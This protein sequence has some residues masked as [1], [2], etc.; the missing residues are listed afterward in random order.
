MGACQGALAVYTVGQ[1]RIAKEHCN[2]FL[3]RPKGF[4]KPRPRDA[5]LGVSAPRDAKRGARAVRILP[6]AAP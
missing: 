3:V 5:P 6:F 4:A 2:A 1:K